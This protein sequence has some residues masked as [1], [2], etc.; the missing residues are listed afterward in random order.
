MRQW[1]IDQYHSRQ[2]HAKYLNIST[3]SWVAM[4]LDILC[5]N[6]HGFV[7]VSHVHLISSSLFK[8]LPNTCMINT[9]CTALLFIS[10]MLLASI[11]ITDY[12]WSYIIMAYVVLCLCGLRISLPRGSNVLSTM[13]KPQNAYGP[14][15]SD[16]CF[17]D[18]KRHYR[19]YRSHPCIYMPMTAL[20]N[21]Q[22]LT[23]MTA[24]R[25]K[26][27]STCCFSGQQNGIWSSTPLKP[28]DANTVSITPA[29]S[30]ISE[31][32]P[33]VWG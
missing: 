17:S 23:L 21:G 6:Q 29:T 13:A 24:E 28:C 5:E 9:K 1:N 19:L 15:S 7:L 27:I 20:P 4:T 33:D 11:Y 2:Y 26:R 30:I 14:I 16:L 3:K 12:S 32:I 8:N 22:L 18:L 10:P 31:K 25:C